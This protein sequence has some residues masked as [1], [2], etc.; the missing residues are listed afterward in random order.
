MILSRLQ[1]FLSASFVNRTQL[2]ILSTPNDK[3]SILE[4]TSDRPLAQL[5][6]GTVAGIYLPTF[7]QNAWLGIPFVKPPTGDNRYRRPQSLTESWEDTRIYESYS[8]FCIGYGSDQAAYKTSEDCLTINVIRPAGNFDEPL[9]VA[10]WIHGG[11]FVKGS[12]S[13]KRY[14]LSSI[15]K[16]S[17]KS[18]QPVI[19]V[20]F[21]Y[22]LGPWGFLS[23]PAIA[24]TGN[25]NL[26]LHDQR[27]ALHW[28]QEN[29][30]GFDGDPDKVT[31]W[32]E[33]AGASSVG[34]HL[35]AYGGENHNLFRAA[36]MQS[37]SPIPITAFATPETKMGAYKT[38]M[39]RLNCPVDGE[40]SLACLRNQTIEGLNNAFDR[41]GT[42]PISRYNETDTWFPVLDGD[43]VR[44]RPSEQLALKQY[45]NV[46]VIVGTCTDEG[47]AYAPIPGMPDALTTS[48]YLAG[49]TSTLNA[50][51]AA[52]LMAKYPSNNTFG[53]PYQLNEGGYTGNLSEVGMTGEYRRVAAYVGDYLFIANHRKTCQTWANDGNPA[54]C[55]RFNAQSNGQP[56]HFG[57]KHLQDVA[58]VFYNLNGDGYDAA[59]NSTQGVNPFEGKPQSYKDLADL[60]SRSWVSFVHDLDP[61]SF[62]KEGTEFEN[63]PLWPQYGGDAQQLLFDADVGTR[64]ETDNYRSDGI[65]LINDNSEQWNR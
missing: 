13:D 48:L 50:F 23:G 39:Q 29:I 8:P 47:T 45:V 56:W 11:G 2:P 59:H 1:I 3:S 54:Y 5:Q 46:P 55:F 22:R 62:R 16:Q 44:R 7:D 25:S 37:G 12:S 63:V 30:Q 34:F 60:M 49:T 17:V 43:F 19:G 64:T 26:G 32:G 24:E 31:I 53:P 51:L 15:V 61:N 35:I 6:N 65:G 52:K 41:V 58:F 42:T 27:L 18:N 36:I 38:I 14:N 57:I 20:S 10:T 33:S 9:P 40:P 21:N 4:D 28:I